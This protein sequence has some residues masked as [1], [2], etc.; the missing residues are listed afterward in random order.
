MMVNAYKMSYKLN[1]NTVRA[2]NIYGSRQYPEKLISK[3]IYNF[4]NNKKM[5]IHGK[6]DNYRHYLSV[7]DFCR[8]N[9]KNYNQGKISRDLQYCI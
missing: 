3:T 4:L 9:V 5:T 7:Q 6:G 1:I 8:G 2:N